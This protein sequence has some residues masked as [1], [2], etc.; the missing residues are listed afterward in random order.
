[1]R[2][3]FE[4]L[5]PL[6]VR[7]EGAALALGGGR[8]RAL[9]GLLLVH[10][11]EVMPRDRIVDELW[12]DS[13][14]AAATR[15]LHVYVSSLRK[16]LGAGAAVLVTR[17][18]GYALEAPPEAIDARR[19]ERLAADGRAALADG[20]AEQAAACLRTALGLWRGDVLADIADERFAA[21][22][23]ARLADLRLAAL[24]DLLAA[25]LALGRHEHAL[26]QL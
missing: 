22:E 9:L 1:M 13:E 2:V 18:P 14:P 8:Q 25:E 23:A 15:S 19:F 6:V 3:E 5:G 26:P 24:E 21:L 10:A 11:N 4:M 20:D 17:P 12:P 7:S 16:A